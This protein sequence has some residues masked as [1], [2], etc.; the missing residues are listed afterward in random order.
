MT[1]INKKSIKSLTSIPVWGPIIQGAS[2]ESGG[3]EN[4]LRPLTSETAAGLGRDLLPLDCY[5]APQ[6]DQYGWAAKPQGGTKIPIDPPKG[7]QV[8]NFNV[9]VL[10]LREFE[11]WIGGNCR[12][13]YLNILFVLS[14]FRISN[15][16]IHKNEHPFFGAYLR[17]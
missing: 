16:Y 2:E 15:F 5:A 8:R 1:K 7:I 14:N 9:F 17:I 13:G 11:F 3:S 12:Y 10:I 4:L 6:S